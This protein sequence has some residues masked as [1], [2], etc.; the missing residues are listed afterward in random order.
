[1]RVMLRHM[2]S[3]DIVEWMGFDYIDPIGAQ[4]ADMQAAL[5]AY[6]VAAVAPKAKNAKKLKLSDFMLKFE[7]PKKKSR[8]QTP[9]E[10]RAAVKYAHLAFGGKLSDIP[11]GF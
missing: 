8:T 2:T 1:M 3:R 5:V 4:R 6:T 9:L 7:P 11:E 10:M